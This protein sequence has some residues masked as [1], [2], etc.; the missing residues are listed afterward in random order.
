MLQMAR[1]Q[2][3]AHRRYLQAIKTLA[4]VQKLRVPSRLQVN[5]GGRHAHVS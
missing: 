1:L 4:Q 3:S 5:I 2:E